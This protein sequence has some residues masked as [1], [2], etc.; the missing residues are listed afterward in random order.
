MPHHRWAKKLLH[1]F[2][3]NPSTQVKFHWVMM[4]FW[5]I[6]ATV[7]CIVAILWPH[8]WVAIGVLYVFLLSIYA[9]WDMDY[10]AVSAAQ[11]SLHSEYLVKEHDKQPR[12]IAVE[13][14]PP[15]TIAQTP[16][17]PRGRTA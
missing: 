2:E 17:S 10:G 15:G 14:V 4:I 8:T 9:N 6:N 11:A 13:E 3:E 7:G 16:V 12:V 5:I 1:D